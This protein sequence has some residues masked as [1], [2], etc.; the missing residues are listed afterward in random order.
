M[1]ARNRHAV[2]LD[3]HELAKRQPSL[4][5]FVFTNV[6]GQPAIDPSP[7]AA[8]PAGFYATFANFCKGPSFFALWELIQWLNDWLK[9]V[10]V[11]QQRQEK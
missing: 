9:A 3:Y 8:K 6:H 11:C 4:K 5:P 2:Y 1:H 10:G 7:P